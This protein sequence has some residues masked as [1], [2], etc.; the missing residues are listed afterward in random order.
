MDKYLKR[1]DA[2]KIL[3]IHYHTL[4]KLS[5]NGEIETI[6]V[7]SQNLYNVDKYLRKKGINKDKNDKIKICYCRVSSRKQKNDL[8]RQVE[9]MKNLYPNHTIIKDI[10]S[11][12]NFKRPGLKKIIKHAING[13]IDELIV[14]FKDRLTRFGFELIEFIIETS[15]NGKIIVLNQTEEKT[16]HEEVT[17]DILQIMNVYV[18]KINGLRKYKSLIKKDIDN[19]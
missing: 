14:A 16:P 10:G 17:E 4:Y 7:G 5:K 15:S 6:K 12:L 13:E 19:L 9:V 2:L 3:G 11:G 1:K 18:A 8:E